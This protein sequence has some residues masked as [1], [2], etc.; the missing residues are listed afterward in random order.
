[1]VCFTVWTMFGVIGIPIR[2]ELGLN[3]ALFGLLTATPVLLT[4]HWFTPG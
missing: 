1:M 2:R 3:N 4:P